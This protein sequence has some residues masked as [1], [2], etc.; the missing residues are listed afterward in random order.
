MPAE[1]AAIGDSAPRGDGPPVLTRA[2]RWSVVG[3]GND[4]TGSVRARPLRGRPHWWAVLAVTL[5]LMALL[6]STSAGRPLTL[7]T[8]TLPVK[9]DAPRH[10]RAA[11]ATHPTT[12]TTTIIE[13]PAT[14]TGPRSAAGGHTTAAITASVPSNATTPTTVANSGTATGVGTG[15]G[16]TPAQ[17]SDRTTEQGYLEPPDNTSVLYPFTADGATQVQVTWPT[18]TVLVLSVDCGNGPQSDQG[19]SSVTVLA[20]ATSGQCQATLS[21]PTSETGTVSYTLTIGPA[22]GA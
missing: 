4:T 22:D 5:A 7:G 2:Y 16:S 10:P 17:A 21:E 20:P 1:T 11:V 3:G 14:D 19:T 6:A 15:E 18:A 13:A 9:P 12:T 8:R